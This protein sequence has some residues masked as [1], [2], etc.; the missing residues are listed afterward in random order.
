MTVQHSL[1]A[2][3]G[4][5]AIIAAFILAACNTPA[6]TNAPT[7]AAPAGGGGSV[8]ITNFAFSPATVTIKAGAAVTW[9]NNDSV[10]HTITA[11][12]ASWDSGSI[13]NGGTFSH[14]FATAGTFT[15][16]CAIH[17]SMKGT[18]TVTS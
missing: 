2:R 4:S 15:Y 11:D 10:S 17:P 8:A 5:L 14:T 1:S 9:T 12:D 16:H 13:A 18:V 6:A 7:G 3:L